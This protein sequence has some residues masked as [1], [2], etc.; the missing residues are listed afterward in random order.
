MDQSLFRGAR[1]MRQA[2]AGL[3][4]QAQSPDF[5]PKSSASL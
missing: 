4:K 5:K 1:A 2:R 3:W